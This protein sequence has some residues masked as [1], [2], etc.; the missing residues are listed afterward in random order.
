M[1]RLARCI[2]ESTLIQIAF[3]RAMQSPYTCAVARGPHVFAGQHCT[4]CGFVTHGEL[5]D[6]KPATWRLVVKK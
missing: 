6:L 4:Q 1:L 5:L 2:D 3:F